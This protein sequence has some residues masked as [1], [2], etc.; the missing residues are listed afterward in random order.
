MN[1]VKSVLR[2]VGAL[3]L[4]S[5]GDD[6]L[7]SP[8]R[9]AVVGTYEATSFTVTQSDITA[10]LLNLGATLSLTLAEDGT[11]TGHL[12]APHLGPGGSDLNEDLTGTW[13]LSG[14]TVTLSLPQATTFLQ[15]A[16]FRFDSNRLIG[17]ETVNETRV[18][19]ELTRVA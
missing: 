4:I 11:A 12:F 16:T 8:S 7:S 9:A 15:D 18:Q 14:E 10:D 2:V 3:A 13:T 6:E 17:D 19:L 1:S 5:C